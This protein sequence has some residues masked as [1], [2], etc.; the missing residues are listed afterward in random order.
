MVNRGY[1]N[2][3][4]III[5]VTKDFLEFLHMVHDSMNSSWK[6]ICESLCEVDI[7]CD[8]IVVPRFKSI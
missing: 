2:I 1:E 5:R 6:M 4:Y 8:S 7:G 3:V